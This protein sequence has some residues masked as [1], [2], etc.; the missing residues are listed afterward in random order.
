MTLK[1]E[2]YKGVVETTRASQKKVHT[3]NKIKTKINEIA[4]NGSYYVNRVYKLEGEYNKISNFNRGYGTHSY[5]IYKCDISTT[6]NDNYIINE[7]ELMGFQL[8]YTL[9]DENPSPEFGQEG[10]KLGVYLNISW[11]Q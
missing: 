11:K 8:T 9:V 10:L 6:E 5:E 1:S 3:V 2:F 7:F 4:S